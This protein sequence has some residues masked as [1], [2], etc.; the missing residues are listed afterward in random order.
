[1]WNSKESL[2]LTN[3]N[4]KLIKY[5]PAPCFH[6]T[7][8]TK[9]IIQ[10]KKLAKEINKQ[11]NRALQQEPT[12]Q[13]KSPICIKANDRGKHDFDRILDAICGVILLFY[14]TQCCS[15][16][17]VA[18]H[19]RY[20]PLQSISLTVLPLQI[21]IQKAPQDAPFLYKPKSS[22]THN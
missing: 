11:T 19:V 14:N 13:A 17:L 9:L 12:C 7:R 4:K 1:M 6:L 2:R 8:M 22:S 16:E 3:V 21:L 10:Q 18:Q 15:Q 20:Y 5:L